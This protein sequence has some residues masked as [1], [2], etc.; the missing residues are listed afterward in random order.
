MN[1]VHLLWS[2]KSIFV[3]RILSSSFH[4]VRKSVTY[5]LDVQIT[6][7]FFKFYFLKLDSYFMA[8]FVEK[9]A[10]KIN[11][12][13]LNGFIHNR[14]EMGRTANAN[15]LFCVWLFYSSW[16]L[17]CESSFKHPINFIKSFNS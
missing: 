2:K 9:D 7:I 16:A 13:D 3:L 14:F 11:Y 1:C 6:D 4:S 8:Q 12:P 17:N 10:E 15:Q 5:R